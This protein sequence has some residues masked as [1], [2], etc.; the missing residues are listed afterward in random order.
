MTTPEPKDKLGTATTRMAGAGVTAPVGVAVVN[1]PESELLDWHAIDWRAV[2]Q[3]VRRP[4]QRIFT[5]SQAGDLKRVRNLQKL[6]PVLCVQPP[7]ATGG[8]HSQSGLVWRGTKRGGSHVPA[9][10]HAAAAT[11][12]PRDRHR[13]GSEHRSVRPEQHQRP[14]WPSHGQA[15]RSSTSR[16]SPPGLVQLVRRRTRPRS[17]SRRPV[18]S[19]NRP[20]PRPPAPPRW[21]A[22]P[23]RLSATRQLMRRLRA[24]VSCLPLYATP[25]GA[26]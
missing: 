2:E 24:F 15:L 18:R 21:S 22:A 1:G 25:F 5:A 7:A 4:R 3:E 20:E 10:G 17:S 19:A 6:M 13:V 23:L 26:A 12:R 16:R 8:C 14:R 9:I 11:P